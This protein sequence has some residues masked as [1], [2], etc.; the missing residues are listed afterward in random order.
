MFRK[1][2]IA[3]RGEIA[4]RII[5]TCKKLGVKTV[6]AYSDADTEAMPVR[7]AD[8]AYNIGPGPAP[9]SY[10]N[11]PRVVKAAKSS[12]VDAVHPGYGFLAENPEFARTCEEVGLVFVGPRSKILGSA[13]NKF[14]SREMARKAGVATI[15]GSKTELDSFEKAEAEANRIGFPV[16]IKA[17]FGGGGRG[18]RIVNHAR[19]LRRAFELAAAESGSAF[20]RS[21]LYLEK[22][23]GNPRHIEV[24]VMAGPRGRIIELGERECS[25]QRRNQKVLEETPSPVM[26]SVERKRLVSLAL[27]AAKAARYENAG[28]VEFMRSSKGEFYYLEINKR[29]QV[30]HLITEMVTGI[31][32]VEQQLRIASGDGLDISQDEVEFNGAAMNCRIN[33]EDPSRNF[34]PTPG[35]VEEYASPGGP[36]IRVDTALFDGAV[37]PEYYD[38]LIAKIASHGE[39]REEAIER[40]K[41]ALSETIITG[42]ETT[43]PVHQAIL[44]HKN[45]LRGE[46][47][48]QLLDKEMASWD[49]SPR[50]SK[51]EVAMLYLATK[52]SVSGTNGLQQQP[53]QDNWRPLPKA[54]TLGRTPLYVEG[55]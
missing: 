5:R 29:I 46:Y 15:P 1:I 36:G 18:M 47:H 38:S 25:L 2:L 17:S 32:I 30:E 37:V 45:F 13:A 42:V 31:D 28:T 55:L 39:T 44:E 16:L 43:I 19:E 23:L 49:L 6:V 48:T 22:H 34:T 53:H 27:K 24:Q 51:E 9:K 33:A 11:I 52:Y 12:R 20:G 21:E 41:I 8:E 7:L 10:L 40:L 4:V 50:L 26:N 54:E 35:R 14:E 3:N